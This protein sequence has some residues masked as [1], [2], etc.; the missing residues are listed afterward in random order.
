[1]IARVL[2]TRP[3][4]SW[5]GLETRF[6]GTAI[7][8][9]MAPTT[10]QAE[11]RDPRPAEAA[12][13][14]LETYDWLVATS[15]RGVAAL[16]ARLAARGFSRLPEGMRV[17]AVG[18]ATARALEEGGA[19]VDLVPTWAEGPALA[20]ALLERLTRGASV[21]LIRPEGAAEFP[22]AAL[23]A[24]GVVVDE[25]PLY[26]TIASEHAAPLADATIAGVYAGVAFTAPS[27]V[28]LWL[29]AARE[30]RGALAKALQACARIAIGATTA[31][32]LSSLGLAA[33]AIAEAPDEGA[34]GDA[35]ARVLGS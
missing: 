10:I 19:K 8:I 32:T 22:A 3:A 28:V 25:A 14:R 5:P 30:R 31:A 27:S 15:G 24:A 2:V 12:L 20:E 13:D 29:D 34:V 26:R 11:P 1:M 16:R 9:E 21:L 7:S 6:R 23:R 17:A 33:D 4:G 35:I 18:A